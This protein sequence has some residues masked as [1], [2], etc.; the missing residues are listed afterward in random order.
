MWET[1]TR[2]LDSC[3]QGDCFHLVVHMW[4]SPILLEAFEVFPDHGVKLKWCLSHALL[5]HCVKAALL[6]W[7]LYL[8]FWFAHSTGRA[9][10][11]LPVSMVQTLSLDTGMLWGCQVFVHGEVGQQCFY[12]KTL[13]LL[14]WDLVITTDSLELSL[15]LFL[16]LF[17]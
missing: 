1:A 16:I 6:K 4:D 2:F 15:P 14:F 7:Q 12:S 3:F 13:V 10:V 9:N 5:S 11:C 17:N 8:S